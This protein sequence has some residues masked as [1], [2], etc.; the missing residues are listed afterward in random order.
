LSTSKDISFSSPVKR[1]FTPGDEKSF[2]TSRETFHK[3]YILSERPS[4]LACQ[5]VQK[6][7]KPLRNENSG[8]IS[9]VVSYN[10]RVKISGNVVKVQEYTTPQIRG[11]KSAADRGKCKRLRDPKE[12]A[13]D[14]AKTGRRAKDKI[15][16]IVNS[17]WGMS[18][19]GNFPGC[20]TVK[21]LTLTY[22]QNMQEESVVHRDFVRF[23]DRLEYELKEKVEYLAVSERQER[24]AWH[25]HV[26]LFSSFVPLAW[27]K[28]NWSATTGQGSFDIQKVDLVS[29]IG[30][31]VAKY[32]SKS[33]TSEADGLSGKHRFWHSEGLKDKSVN[34]YVL[35]KTHGYLIPDILDLFKNV[36][37]T[38]P[39]GTMRI[40]QGVYDG[41]YTGEVNWIEVTLTPCPETLY[42]VR[43]LTES[44]HWAAS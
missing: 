31:Y 29:N 34:L 23:I 17:N 2:P 28:R 44:L 11:R 43:L 13:Q 32:V 40:R 36:I 5:E 35:R 12:L 15:M 37:A 8:R 25:I 6:S 27:L 14:I 21:F 19:R 39:D 26:V 16:D 18:T 22:Q 3:Q 42:L 4:S 30:R 24:G 33:F 7:G 10:Q 38:R 9:E 1:N 20:K 41:E